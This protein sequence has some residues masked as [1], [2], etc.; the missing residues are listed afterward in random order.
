MGFGFGYLHYFH[1]P[2]GLG[3]LIF[4]CH[5]V[6]AVLDGNANNLIQII[7][8]IPD[9]IAYF[10]LYFTIFPDFYKWLSFLPMLPIPQ[11]SICTRRKIDDKF[12]L[13]F[14]DKNFCK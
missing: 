14:N 8:I 2:N 1:Y 11:N 9:T 7:Y 12:I 13:N 3:Y 6:A 5:T 10:N 4:C